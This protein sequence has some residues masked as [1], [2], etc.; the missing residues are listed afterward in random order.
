MKTFSIFNFQ[1]SIFKIA[2]LIIIFN[3]QFSILNSADAQP[4]ARRVQQAQQQKSAASNLTTRAQISYP[5]AQQM[6]EDVVWRRDIYRELDL[7]QGANSG[8]YYPVEPVG[9]QMNLFTYLFK[10]VLSG[11]VKAYEYRLDGNESFEADAVVKPLSLLDNYH[12]YYEKK[13][14]RLKLDNS[15]IP[16]RE[17]K[18]YYVKESAYYDQNSATFH[19]KVIALCPIMSREDDFGDGA[20][21][22]PLFWV[23][24]DDVAPFLTKQTIMTSDLNNAATMSMDDYFVKNM[25][26]GKIYKTNNMLGQTLAQYCP[27]DSAMAK[28]QKKIEAELLA[29]EKNIWGDPVKKDSL[30]SIAKAL[31]ANPKVARKAAKA[32]RRAGGSA[33][34][35][36]KSNSSRSTSSD[37]GSSARVSVRRQRH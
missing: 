1:F 8:M 14:G 4:Q 24:Y 27:T 12:I 37:A 7:M 2:A 23:K 22:Y 28:E 30:D 18:S 19:N 17:V 36:K 15:D 16:S 34:V 5:T 31:A 35:A 25:Y 13:D 33:K 6:K 11:Q 32:N 26:Q 10:L 9:S 20:S 21:K 3:C 29:F